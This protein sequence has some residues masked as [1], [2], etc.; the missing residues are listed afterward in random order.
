MTNSP[1]CSAH[2]SSSLSD[3][4][5]NGSTSLSIECNFFS[6]VL[7]S[8]A[9]IHLL[10]EM[11]DSEGRSHTSTTS[12]TTH[13]ASRLSPDPPPPLFGIHFL[14]GTRAQPRWFLLTFFMPLLV[15]TPGVSSLREIS[16][17][18]FVSIKGIPRIDKPMGR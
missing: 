3:S 9:L 10:C 16:L 17:K 18:S 13:P 5:K 7:Q 8:R 14:S 6:K 4:K 11:H 1:C 12:L 15:F 2:L